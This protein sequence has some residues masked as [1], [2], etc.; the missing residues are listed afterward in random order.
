MV[1]YWWLWNSADV[2]ATIARLSGLLLGV[3]GSV[4]LRSV[5][6][7]QLYGVKRFDPVV[8][9]ITPGESRRK[10]GDFPRWG[11][12]GVWRRPA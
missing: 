9:S 8:L 12:C 7:S 11:T 3:A 1:I 10:L 4:A 6:E 2:K 5:V